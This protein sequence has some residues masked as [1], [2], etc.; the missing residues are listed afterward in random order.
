MSQAGG[1]SSTTAS[2]GCCSTPVAVVIEPARDL[3]EQTAACLKD[4]CRFLPVIKVDCFIGSSDSRRGREQVDCHIAGS[5]MSVQPRAFVGVSSPLRL[6]M[7]MNSGNSRTVA[8]PCAVPC[9]FSC[10]GTWRSLP[11]TNARS[12]RRAAIFRCDFLF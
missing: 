7:L 3:A 4:Y 6:L 5:L 2:P 1:S 9:H 10:Q 11:R 8:G 12:N